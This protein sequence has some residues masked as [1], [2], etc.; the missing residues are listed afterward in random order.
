MTAPALPDDIA[1]AS[2]RNPSHPGGADPGPPVEA[3]A[4]RSR[5]LTVGEACESADL[6]RVEVCSGVEVRRGFVPEEDLDLW[7]ASGRRAGPGR[8]GSLVSL[9]RSVA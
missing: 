5:L 8:A 7:A 6:T 2:G 9:A 1:V 3:V 4:P